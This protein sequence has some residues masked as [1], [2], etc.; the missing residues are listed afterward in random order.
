MQCNTTPIDFRRPA[1][2]PVFYL[3][4]EIEIIVEGLVAVCEE[5]SRVGWVS[6]VRPAARPLCVTYK[7]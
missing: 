7:L 5:E 4:H 3:L 2:E 6:E 1:I